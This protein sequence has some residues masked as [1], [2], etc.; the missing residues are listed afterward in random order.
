MPTASRTYWL[1]TPCRIHRQDN[2]LRIDRDDQPST[3]I[4]IT[5]VRDIIAAAPVDINTSTIALLNTHRINLHLLSHYGDYAGSLLSADTATSG[6]VV[7]AQARLAEQTDTALPIARSIVDNAAF[8]IRRC[9]DRRLL[10]RPYEVL[11][12]AIQH[13]DTIEQLMAAE[14]NF[15]RSAWEVLDTKLPD[16]LQLHGRHRRPPANAGN[17]F[18]SYANG[19]TYSR[20]LSALRLTPLHT[21]IAFLHSSLHRR[22]HSLALDLAEIFKPLFAERLLLRLAGRKQLNPKHFDIDTNQAMLSD[23]GRKLLITTIRDELGT[24]IDHRGLKRPVAYDELPYLDALTL[25]RTCLEGTPYKPFRI[26]W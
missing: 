2:S 8:N 12:Q 16:W 14:G 23:T 19:I 24:T 11:T 21:G 7:L 20:V 15:R 6:H 1:T 9:I 17:A 13:A 10:H 22:R 4:P 3:H 25:T 5:D 18:I 26:W